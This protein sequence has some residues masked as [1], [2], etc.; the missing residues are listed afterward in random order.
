MAVGSDTENFQKKFLS[1]AALQGAT[2]TW[3]PKLGIFW[4]TAIDHVLSS[5]PVKLHHIYSDKSFRFVTQNWK[6]VDPWYHTDADKNKLLISNR[7]S[8]TRLKWEP[9]GADFISSSQ[10]VN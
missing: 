3:A 6:N 9:S 8:L 10:L 2:C 4:S 5:I 1:H 7:R